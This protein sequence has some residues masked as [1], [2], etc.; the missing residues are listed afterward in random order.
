ML[1]L[2][3]Q[4]A[5]LADA[6]VILGVS[7]M[8]HIGIIA[9]PGFFSHDEWDRVDFINEYGFWGY[10]ARFMP[11]QVGPE[12]GHPV[13]PIGFVQ[14]GLS[15]L[16]MPSAP[17]LV[18]GF[19]V[20][21]HTG[22][23]LLLYFAVSSLKAPRSFSVLAGLAFAL[24]PLTTGAVGWVGASFDQWYTLF[25]IAACWVA[26][27]I[28]RDGIGAGRVILLFLLAAG[29]ILSKEAAV[30]LPGLILMAIV[31]FHL[32][33]QP[34][35]VYLRR[36]GVAVLV[37]L[38]P[39]LA[40]LLIRLPA[41]MVSFSGGGHSA[42]SPSLGFV[43]DNAVA[44]FAFPLLVQPSEMRA[45]IG[46]GPVQILAILAHLGL[47]IWLAQ[48]YSWLIAGAYVAAYFLPLLPVLPLPQPA[49]HYIH[50]SA[51][52]LALAL[53]ALASGAWHRRDVAPLA[54][55]GGA[56]LVMMLH[57]LAIQRRYYADGACQSRF[58]VSLPAHLAAL[59]PV[60]GPVVLHAERRARTATM[61][62]ALHDRRAYDGK[63]GRPLVRFAQD[64]P[65]GLEPALRLRVT[66]TC[67]IR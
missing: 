29:A 57:N 26:V 36:A 55:L 46:F 6:W 50:G 47:I 65:A 14:Q 64:L 1:R 20:L 54:V 33:L 31:S 35:E 27:L 38:L 25:C 13:R 44:Y 56:A 34:G 40:Y 63:G 51:V 58:M 30:V 15:A 4:L 59:E 7:V 66:P 12:F 17:I 28:Y 19:D 53:A 9:N 2:N 43:L 32:L 61:R 5:K 62:R 41:L 21:L 52:P 67:E 60:P 22:I 49:A 23:A 11:V 8:G 3:A 39:I 48:R 37:S 42:Y 16:G 10:M 24:S 18:H 45:P